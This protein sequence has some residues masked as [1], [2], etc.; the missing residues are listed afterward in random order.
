MYWCEDRHLV[1]HSLGWGQVSFGMLGVN[2]K[3]ERF[4]EEVEEVAPIDVA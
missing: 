1:K 2:P 3:R 4:V